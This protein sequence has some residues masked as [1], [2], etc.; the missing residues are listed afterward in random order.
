MKKVYN[1][2]TF[3]YLAAK[4]LSLIAT[5]SYKK[6][7]TTYPGDNPIRDRTLIIF[8]NVFYPILDTLE[9][10]IEIKSLH[11]FTVVHY[12]SHPRRCH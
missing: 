2:S 3:F 4:F 5:A 10:P 1:W 11:R 6:F 7:Y 8:T 12:M 9:H